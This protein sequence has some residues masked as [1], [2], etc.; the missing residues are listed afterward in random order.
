MYKIF[1]ILIILA[2]PLFL[3]LTPYEASQYGSAIL[4]CNGNFVKYWVTTVEK[5]DDNNTINYVFDTMKKRRYPYDNCTVFDCSYNPGRFENCEIPYD[6]K[7]Q[8]NAN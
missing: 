1:S 2:S 7:R 3:A 6:I 5:D 8:K 4:V